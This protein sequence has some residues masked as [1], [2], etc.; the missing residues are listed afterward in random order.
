MTKITL[1]T[2]QLN[3]WYRK[4]ARDLPWRQTR[5]PYKIWISEVMLQ[6]TTVNAA[7]PYYERWIKAFP[8]VENVARAS[9]QKILKMWQGLGY[10]N[11]A[12]NLHKAAKL[13][14]KEYGGKI[15]RDPRSIT[16]FTRIWPLYCW[17]GLKYCVRYTI[18]NY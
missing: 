5:D 4:H 18:S 7:I 12:R 8:K 13:I 14:A 11:R 16:K 9:S 6:Q 17:G 15:P 2:T 3:V 10:Y 1:F